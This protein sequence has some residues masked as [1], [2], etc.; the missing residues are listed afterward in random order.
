MALASPP[1][2]IIIDNEAKY[3]DDKTDMKRSILPY[4]PQSINYK[5]EEQNR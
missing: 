1:I 5:L 2:G 4:T 3:E